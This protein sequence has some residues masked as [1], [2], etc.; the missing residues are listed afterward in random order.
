M[1]TPDQIACEVMNAWTTPDGV[2]VHSASREAYMAKIA[3]AIK[4]DRAQHDL[5]YARMVMD[6]HD[7]RGVIWER[8]DLESVLNGRIEDEE[9]PMPDTN[10]EYDAIIDRAMESSYWRC[11]DDPTDSDWEVIGLALDEALRGERT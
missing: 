10:A 6:R 4:A 8:A 5:P 1:K 3:E 9:I 7:G 11:L 2:Q